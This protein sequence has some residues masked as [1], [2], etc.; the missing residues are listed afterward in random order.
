MT[1]LAVSSREAIYSYWNTPLFSARKKA[2]PL[3]LAAIGG[4]I[5]YKTCV[6][7]AAIIIFVA[8]PILALLDRIFSLKAIIMSNPT[9][10]NFYEGEKNDKGVTLE[11]IW[12]WDD[13]K[14]E[15]HHDFIQWLFP[16]KTKS[17]YNPSAS[18]TDA[19]TIA[20]FK[21]NNALQ[22]KM[23]KSL[24]VMLKFYGF[25]RESNRINSN[26]TF[27]QKARNWLTSD[28]H[29]FKRISRI[30]RSLNLH[31]LSL[32]AQAFY[33]ALKQIYGLYPKEIGE[34]TFQQWTVAMQS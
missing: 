4:N 18:I 17:P 30:L 31:G 7:I 1:M 12:K 24:D 15:G 26:S 13:Q 23:C 10:L 3:K 9:I 27:N 22:E 11:E 33:G 21:N 16:H 20:K 19:K 29:N 6:A 28:N 8:M 5:L 25:T 2:L 32:E 34:E 14:L